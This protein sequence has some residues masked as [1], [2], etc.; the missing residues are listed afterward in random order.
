MAIIVTDVQT[1][2]LHHLTYVHYRKHLVGKEFAFSM[3]FIAA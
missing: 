3:E 1:L 2:E